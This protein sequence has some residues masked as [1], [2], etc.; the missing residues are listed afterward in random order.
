MHSSRPATRGLGVLGFR[1]LGFRGLGLRL[2]VAFILKKPLVGV[3][4]AIHLSHMWEQAAFLLQL[5][6]KV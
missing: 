2:K 4:F 6:C 5:F 3:G 1:G